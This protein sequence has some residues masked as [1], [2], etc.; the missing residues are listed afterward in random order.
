MD[1]LIQ[2]NEHGRRAEID[3]CSKAFNPPN[4]NRNIKY[5]SVDIINFKQG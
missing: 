3:Q 4:R 2:H 5:G 1:V